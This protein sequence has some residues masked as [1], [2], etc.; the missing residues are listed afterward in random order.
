MEQIKTPLNVKEM[1]PKR[2]VEDKLNDTKMGFFQA[3]PR[4]VTSHGR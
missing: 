2:Y 1:K 4:P 3:Q